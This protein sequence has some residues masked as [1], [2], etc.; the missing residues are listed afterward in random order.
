MYIYIDKYL[1]TISTPEEHGRDSL[2]FSLSLSYIYIYMCVCMYTQ[3]YVYEYV[4]AG[5]AQ[6][7]YLHALIP[8]CIYIHTHV[9]LY[10][11]AHTLKNTWLRMHD[12]CTYTHMHSH[13]KLDNYLHV[14]K[15]DV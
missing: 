8:E 3:V 11:H 6:C 10:S 7:A 5:P 2:V 1:Y 15:H 13:T 9:H 4:H 12:T 14:S